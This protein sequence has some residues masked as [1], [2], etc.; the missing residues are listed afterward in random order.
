MK[1]FLSIAALAV[2]TPVAA[3]TCAFHQ[4]GWDA[5]KAKG[6]KPAKKYADKAALVSIA[7]DAQGG[8]TASTSTMA[9]GQPGVAWAIDDLVSALEPMQTKGKRSPL[10]M[11]FEDD[12]LVIYRLEPAAWVWE[13]APDKAFFLKARDREG[14]AQ[15]H[16]PFGAAR[17]VPGHPDM[18]AV[19]NPSNPAYR[20][21]K[22]EYNLG[23]VVRRNT[24]DGVLE[25]PIIIDPEVKNGNDG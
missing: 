4:P 7:L 9:L 3:Q 6:E 18:I 19:R 8:L 5:E 23:V 2:A 17:P 13:T 16:N 24:A 25:T 15:R 1:T 10:D 22:Y 21:C 11:S 14:R 20:G 12:T